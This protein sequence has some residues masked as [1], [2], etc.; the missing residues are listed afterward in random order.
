KT[1]ASPSPIS[2]TPAFSP[3]PQ[4]TRGPVVGRVRS[5]TFDDLYEQC[6]LHIA[7][8]MPVSVRFGV[9]PRSAQARSNSSALSPSSAARSAVTLLPITLLQRA[10]EAIEQ[11]ASV[12]PPQQGIGCILGMRHQPEHRAAVVEDAGDGAGRAVDIVLV[13]QLARRAAIAERDE[14]LVLQTV[15]RALVGSVVA[16]VVGGRHPDR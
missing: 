13:G 7:A 6:S 8:M 14:A 11:R 1:T 12:S 15:E 2:I 16:V 3:G 5:H 9:R 10:D 4:I